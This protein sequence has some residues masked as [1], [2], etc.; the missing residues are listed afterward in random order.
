LLESLLS[1]DPVVVKAA[2]ASLTA[3][4]FERDLQTAIV[5]AGGVGLMCL[6]VA[7]S[8]RWPQPYHL[9]A[10][11]R[12]LASRFLLLLSEGDDLKV[13][14]RLIKFRHALER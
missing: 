2:V 8:R 6:A 14:G 7:R 9:A 4:A 12:A 1:D 3:L 5:D 13:M 10:P 11:M